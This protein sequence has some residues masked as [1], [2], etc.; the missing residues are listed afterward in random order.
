MGSP[1]SI[2]RISFSSR[3]LTRRGRDLRRGPAPAGGAEGRVTSKPQTAAPP[4]TP[5]F[6]PISRSTKARI[7][8]P[9]D[10]PDLVSRAD[11]RAPESRTLAGRER[12]YRSSPNMP[13]AYPTRRARPRESAAV[14]GLAPL[15]FW[16][17]ARVNAEGG[18][19]VLLL[20]SKALDADMPGSP[21]G[22][23]G[24]S[25]R[26]PRPRPFR[27]GMASIRTT[28]GSVVSAT[29]ADRVERPSA[30]PTERIPF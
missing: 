28:A 12:S 16:P 13:R 6:R 11:P 9:R 8:D 3:R 4:K 19:P 23:A 14:Y 29:V 25:P 17:P 30:P 1:G 7:Q 21:E 27:N 18:Q 5:W 20:A 2:S 10:P 15:L 24:P 22:R 26:L